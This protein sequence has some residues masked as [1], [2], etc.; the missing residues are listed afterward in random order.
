VRLS[1]ID[2]VDLPSISNLS[3]YEHVMGV[4]YLAQKAPIG[5]R[6]SELERLALTASALLHDWA[7]T[8][9]GHL[10]EEALQYVGTNFDHESRLKEIATGT[11]S[12]D[13]G[14]L[15]D[16][17]VLHGRNMGLR[18]WSDQVTKSR[19]ESSELIELISDF[20]SGKG[21]AGRL[22]AGTIDLDNIDNVFRMAYHIG[23]DVDRACPLRLALAM[24]K[25]DDL[26]G[27][28]IFPASAIQDI[29]LWLKTRRQVYDLL[30]LAER[31]FAG[32]TMLIYATTVAFRAM[33]IREA[34]WSLT[35]DAFFW[36]LITSRAPKAS[37]TAKRWASG[38]LWDM[39]P[40][41]W[42]KGE[43]PDYRELMQFSSELGELLGRECFAYGIRDKRER[44]LSIHIAGAA[45]RQLGNKS[46]QWLFGFGSPIR[47]A[48]SVRDCDRA[49]AFAESRFVSTLLRRAGHED[50]MG[51]DLP[52]L[53]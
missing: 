14:G 30:M 20:I 21:S 42:M 1:N 44:V 43:R 24:E 34:D 52:W 40:I 49:W 53:I 8:A 51:L 18:E 27:D 48:F 26:T 25:V 37:E 33:E 28:P 31:D 17:Q 5:G 32:K 38:E 6:L 4:A 7:I 19:Y 47:K 35:D 9:Y 23:L 29:Q 2:S 10:V 11:S 46:E 36:R 15:H 3:R 39:A 13:L 22:I 50:R 45:P 41:V 16:R 12:A